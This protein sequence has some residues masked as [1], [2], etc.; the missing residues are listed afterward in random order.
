VAS[1]LGGHVGFVERPAVDR[2]GAGI[3]RDLFSRQADNAL[4]EILGRVERI[5]KGRTRWTT[6]WRR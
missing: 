5:V 2:D 3:D 6:I 1:I 4:D